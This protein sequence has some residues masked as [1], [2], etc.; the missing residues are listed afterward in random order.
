MKS[1]PSKVYNF[2]AVIT[3]LLVTVSLA[4]LNYTPGT[5]QTGWDTLHPEFNFA[6]N[7]PRHLF[8]IWQENQG[9]GSVGGHSHAADISRILVLFAMSS[10]VQVQFLRYFFLFL[11]LIF[12]PI[13]AYFFL[14]NV[15]FKD[16][17]DEFIKFLI[18]L[19][20]SLYYLLNL[21]TVQQYIVQLEMYTVLYGALPWF[22]L[23]SYSYLK[24]PSKKN[25]MV[26]FAVCFLNAPVAYSIT[27]FVAEFMCLMSFFGIYSIVSTQRTRADI[28]TGIR[29]IVRLGLVVIFFNS[30]WLIPSLYFGLTKSSFVSVSQ[31]N[32]FFSE[33]IFGSNVKHGN[34]KDLVL[35]K[36]FLTE[37]SDFDF[38]RNTWYPIMGQ[39]DFYLRKP[40]P[41]VA[42]TVV[43]VTLVL[44]LCYLLLRKNTF[45]LPILGLFLLVSFMF[46]TVNVPFGSIFS[47]LR[48]HVKVLAEM[49]RNPYTKFSVELELVY[50]VFFSFGVLAVSDI[51]SYITNKLNKFF[52][53]FGRV[54][55][56]AGYV[57]A[58][59]IWMYPMFRG[60]LISTDIRLKIPT[61]YFEAFD[62]LNSQKD[63]RRIALLPIPRH[64]GWE[65]YDWGYQGA[66]FFWFGTK[67]PVLTRDFDRWNRY[68]EEYYFDM[69]H[70]IYAKNIAEVARVVKKYD[71]GY[72]VIDRSAVV[73]ESPNRLIFTNEIQEMLSTSDLFTNVSNFDKL[74]IYKLRE[75]SSFSTDFRIFPEDAELTIDFPFQNGRKDVSFQSKTVARVGGNIAV[76]SSLLKTDEGMKL[77][78]PSV[79]EYEDFYPAEV[80]VS[81]DSSGKLNINLK[82]KNIVVK[83]GE[84]RQDLIPDALVHTV[85]MPKGFKYPAVLSL[86][87]KRFFDVEK[88]PDSEVYLGTLS[89]D[90]TKELAVNIISKNS[91]LEEIRA[92]PGDSEFLVCSAGFDYDVKFYPDFV[93]L[94]AGNDSACTFNHFELPRNQNGYLADIKLSFQTEFYNLPRFCFGKNTDYCSYAAID[95]AEYPD[96]SDKFKSIS[97]FVEFPYG[98]DLNFFLLLNR[99][100]GFDV[101]RL[102]Y[103]DVNVTVYPVSVR[104]VISANDIADSL[105]SLS[106]EIAVEGG[107]NQSVVVEFP[108]VP[109]TSSSDQHLLRDSG[110]KA[111]EDGEKISP[112]LNSGIKYSNKEGVV[113]DDVNFPLL[114]NN[115]SYLFEIATENIAGSTLRLSIKDIDYNK[116]HA[117]VK[118]FS[119]VSYISY[120]KK[121]SRSSVNDSGLRVAFFQENIGYEKTENV[122]KSIN[123]YQAPLNWISNFEIKTV[124]WHNDGLEISEPSVRKLTP[125][126]YIL[127]GG[128]LPNAKVGFYQS[129]DA[130]WVAIGA[131]NHGILNGWANIWTANSNTVVVLFVPGFIQLILYI[132]IVMFLLFSM[133]SKTAKNPDFSV[134]QAN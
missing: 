50:A 11:T 104:S 36:G 74:E 12:G 10:I 129:F 45:K 5:W 102:S 23:A 54:S 39:W 130:G 57:L 119:P 80:Y 25:L 43:V 21:G 98:D 113:Y 29:N 19:A 103:K 99:K 123:V 127:T 47:F 9:L 49:F 61:Y 52:V 92:F 26:L 101:G 37:W 15:I 96:S 22:F 78:V 3:L 131:R 76:S 51:I 122:A 105:R 84:Q 128:A 111:N 124:G 40:V 53:A 93:S 64:E 90:L 75:N 38:V 69:S 88:E 62:W 28:L 18:S 58:L 46:L 87:G 73:T 60:Y 55:I 112:Y 13:G 91:S 14:R 114:A 126:A 63:G 89:V 132:A 24:S 109:V 125:F 27:V 118:A 66:G 82:F 35:N 32:V 68:N 17:H 6:I 110:I 59:V 1:S 30:Y 79:L 97:K 115:A 42:E 83:I 133:T 106:K 65:Y 44:G 41:K 4:I 95:V 67:Q 134:R 108:E 116:I 71:I 81:S 8:G 2:I 20:G 94:L 16:L 72:L 86:G 56:F 33:S 120:L 7:I 31:I 85:T 100:E 107:F 77:S 121:F 34:F 48:E 117:E 70:A